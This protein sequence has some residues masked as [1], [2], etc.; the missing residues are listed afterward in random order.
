MI[1]RKNTHAPI[2]LPVLIMK[3]KKLSFSVEFTASCKYSIG[4]EQ[5]DINKLFGVG[6]FPSHHTN[7][8]RFGWRYISGDE[9]EILAYWY[10]NRVRQWDVIGC[11]DIG[12]EYEFSLI[13]GKSNHV[14]SVRSDGPPANKIVNVPSFGPGYLLRPYFGGNM[15]APHDIE[16][17]IKKANNEN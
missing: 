4:V 10:H 12:K 11:V 8:V 9:I 1:I 6:Y 2:R 16:I 14:L 3:P 17:I 15:K 13:P 5:L 7:S